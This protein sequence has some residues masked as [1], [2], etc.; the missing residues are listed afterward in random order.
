[1]ELS[2]AINSIYPIEEPV[3]KAIQQ[4]TRRRTLP[5]GT[6]LLSEG[7]ISDEV[8]FI[9][10]GLIRAFYYKDSKE[11]TSWMAYEGRFIWPLP[12]Y[13]LQRPSR[14]NIQL[15]EKTTLLSMHRHDLD[16]LKQEFG[17]FEDLQCR[18]MERYILL[19][20]LR[21]QLLLLKAE[22]RLEGYQ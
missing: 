11:I 20:D 17:I 15:L 12:S 4:I 2:T 6:V 14:E 8:H 10:K 18:I 9:E 16:R 5:K 19:Y 7:D 22:E 3:Q 13:L 1:M 21:V